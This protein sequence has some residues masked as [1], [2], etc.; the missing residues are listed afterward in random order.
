MADT[1]GIFQKDEYGRSILVSVNPGEERKSY[2]IPE[3][4]YAVAEKAFSEHPELTRISIPASLEVIPDRALSNGGG[5]ASDEKGIDDIRV[6]SGN[7][8]FFIENGCLY[9][10][11]PG[12]GTRLVRA[13]KVPENV[14]IPEHVCIVARGAFSDRKIACVTLRKTGQKIWFPVRHDYYLGVLLDEFG[15]NG[16]IYDFSRYDRFLL[17]NHFNPERI[18]MIC[19]RIADCGPDD[20]ETAE[21]LTEHVRR[22]QE[23]IL[24]CLSDTGETLHLDCLADIGFFTADNMDEII[25]YFSRSDR[26]D[27]LSWLMNYKHGHLMNNEADFDFSI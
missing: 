2:D 23:Q 21:K 3:G 18:R 15:K 14:S 27:L 19:A 24:E 6:S 16:R 5:W 13:A 10:K 8:V 9:E 25:E 22:Y 26:K 1:L 12:Q 17:D 7:D 4:T 11:L 20:K